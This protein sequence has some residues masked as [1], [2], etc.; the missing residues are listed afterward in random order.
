MGASYESQSNLKTLSVLRDRD[1]ILWLEQELWMREGLSQ[2]KE[3]EQYKCSSFLCKKINILLLPFPVASLQNRISRIW[4]A[5]F[6][7]HS[8]FTKTGFSS[9]SYYFLYIVLDCGKFHV[10][11]NKTII[12]LRQGRKERYLQLSTLQNHIQK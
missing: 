8:S 11:H 7:T 4:P 9:L 5:V 1:W 12:S 6:V 10:N 2:K 3:A